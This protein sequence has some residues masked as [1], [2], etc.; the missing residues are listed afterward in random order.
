MFILDAL[1]EPTLP[2]GGSRRPVCDSSQ[3]WTKNLLHESIDNHAV[4]SLVTSLLISAEQRL[5]KFEISLNKT[6]IGC[7]E[8]NDVLVRWLE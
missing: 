5:I 7:A 6:E 4:Q 8:Q 2:L 1:T 3:A